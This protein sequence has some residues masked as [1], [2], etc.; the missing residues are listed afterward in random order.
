MASSGVVITGGG[1]GIGA[2]V[3]RQCAR[4][5][6]AVAVLDLKDTDE[7]GDG[8][9]THFIAC[10]VTDPAALARS[11]ETAHRKLG[12]IDHV[13][14]NAGV[15]GVLAPIE[16]LSPEEWRATLA[17]CLDGVFYTLRAAIPH[18]ADRGGAIVVTSSITGTRSFATEGAAAYAAAKAGIVALVQLAAVELGRYGIRV[19]AV[20][21]GAV[22][23][24]R[25]WD[26]STRLRNLDKLAHERL[27][28]APLVG[29]PTTSADVADLVLFLLSDAARRIS[30]AVIHIDG[31]QSLLGGGVLR[32]GRISNLAPPAGDAATADR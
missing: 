19:N 5:G 18:L 9:T 7:V 23:D 31:A 28:D 15:N 4:R 16:D 2:M 22:L 30:G 8:V 17:V 32:Q 21:P 6:F 11:F 1:S 3:A 24:T 25:L 26:L 14:A 20:A 29:N 27:I 12:R 10:D 13:F